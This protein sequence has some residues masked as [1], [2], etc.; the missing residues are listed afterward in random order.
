MT[1]PR[2]SDWL[3]LA[4]LVVIWGS[5]FALLKVA[6]AHIPPVWATTER[7]W[8]AVLTLGVVILLRREKLPGLD[9]GAWKF[10]LANGVVGM[11]VPF[12]LFALAAERIPSAMN[13]ICNGATPIFTALMAH[14]IVPGE[15]MN[16]IKAAGVGLGFGGLLVL[17]APRLAGGMS[18]EA[19]GL[20]LALAAAF[21][22]AV[23]NILTKQA[24]A[25]SPAVGAWM[26]CLWGA[27][28]AT[29]IALVFHAPL[30]LPPLDSALAVLAHGVFPTGLS[31]IGWIYL[32][33]HRGTLF[34]SMAVYVAPLW[35]TGVGVAFMG[36]RPG[37]SAFLALALILSGVGL[38]TFHPRA[39][40]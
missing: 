19:A 35:A 5:A 13:S 8:V 3:I 38:A 20:L 14:L 17:V 9:H 16:R 15:R 31:T 1:R 26:M 40:A 10:Y 18:L 34:T 22:Y 37:V 28:A 7:L 29:L 30:R 25:V 2:P 12:A 24:P 23:S 32:I 39:R 33:Q 4:S 6:V 27:V 36:E 21:L 11:A